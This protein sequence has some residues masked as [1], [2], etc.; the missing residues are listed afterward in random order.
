MFYSAK[1]ASI[2]VNDCRM[3]YICFGT[4]TRPL[5]IIP[6]LGFLRLAGK[7]LPMAWAYR[8][9]AR[10]YRVYVF[11]RKHHISQGYSIEDMADELAQTLT[12]LQIES[13]D[14]IGIS[15]GG[16]IAQVLTSRYPQLVGKLVL[17]ATSS[18]ANRTVQEVVGN[19]IRLAKE[20]NRQALMIDMLEKVYSDKYR[21]K[22]QGLVTVLSIVLK[23][24][25]L[26]RFIIL[27]TSILGF[28]C[29][30]E[31]PQI[32]CPVLVLGGAQDQVVGFYA[33][34]ELV[35][36]LA[37]QSYIYQELGHSIYEEAKD[38]PKRL[39]AFL[40]S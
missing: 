25:D 15:Q 5:V 35:D 30:K 10:F 16:M 39:L 11:E 27:A 26:E 9:F 12:A 28:D 22:Y 31:L 14:V 4:G 2:T 19:W 8:L 29:V 38:F 20:N 7:A 34:Q 40:L 3:D 13:A 36:S 24:S 37:S 32:S 1:N 17:V 6:G 21:K 33:A 18:R 23:P